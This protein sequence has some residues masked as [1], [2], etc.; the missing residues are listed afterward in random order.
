M[1]AHE[2]A[3]Q[4]FAIA[5]HLLQ[6]HQLLRD[7]RGHEANQP[8]SLAICECLALP[9]GSAL[10][11]AKN[12]HALLS[13]HSTIP[14]PSC[15]TA[16]AGVDFL[17]RQAVLVSCSALESFFWDVL[18]ENALTVV[19]AKGRKSDDS[20]KNVTLTL[21]DYMSLQSYTDPDERLREIILKRF[22]RGTLY[23]IAKLDEI[24]GILTVPAKEF[25]K[26]VSKKT[27]LTEGEI[28]TRI[29]SLVSRRNEITHRADRPVDGTPA[30]DCDGHGLRPITSA[31]VST[32]V[33]NAKALVEAA[34]LIFTA[35]MAKL[36]AILTIQAEQ[37]LA[38]ATLAPSSA[39]ATP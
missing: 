32:Y 3:L 29:G 31:W 39:P 11:H 9:A 20:L 12:S 6:L 35:A 19:K 8:L 2:L 22:E 7:L 1:R 25:W 13:A 34:S 17:L 38:Q 23:D 30:A 15:L 26:D 37:S 21:D 10:Q 5:E 33:T 36:E 28:K 14:V 16:P 24:A 18:R 4:N 27:G